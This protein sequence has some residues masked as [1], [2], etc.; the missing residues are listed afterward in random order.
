MSPRASSPSRSARSIMYFAMRALMD[1]EGLRYSSLDHIPST[2]TSG[3]LPIAS[4]IVPP[5]RRS[6]P[7]PGSRAAPPPSPRRVPAPHAPQNAP[8]WWHPCLHPMCA[9]QP[10]LTLRRR[11]LVRWPPLRGRAEPITAAWQMAMGAG[12][13]STCCHPR[14]SPLIPVH[15]PWP[16]RWAAVLSL[17]WR[18]GDAQHPRLD[19][20]LTAPG[21]NPA[22]PAV[23]AA[24]GAPSS[25][26]PAGAAGLTCCAGSNKSP[27]NCGTAHPARALPALSA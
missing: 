20:E 22:H 12:C 3:V 7:A 17:R 5:P 2:M 10:C 14:A 24:G 26:R 16:D 21:A 11:T 23:P 19:T 13:A 27:A 15:P 1:P 25:G 9:A 8:R 18:R 6:K 4:K